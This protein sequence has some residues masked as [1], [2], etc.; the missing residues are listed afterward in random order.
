MFKYRKRINIFVLILVFFFA[1]IFTS[2]LNKFIGD[3]AQF[4][5]GINEKI[6]SYSR[7]D[8]DQSIMFPIHYM[9]VFCAG[10]FMYYKVNDE[11]IT[12][13]YNV[14]FSL[15]IFSILFSSIGVDDRIIAFMP[16]FIYVLF[17]WSL[18][19]MKYYFKGISKKIWFVGSHFL[20][21]VLLGYVFYKNFHMVKMHFILR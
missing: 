13:I 7:G 18:K 9:Y 16:P 10:L 4:L 1:I 17:Y 19:H 15:L 14:L 3:N 5:L 12:I 6:V 21:F 20:C 2:F 8:L 11:K